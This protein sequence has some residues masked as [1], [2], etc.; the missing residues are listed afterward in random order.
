MTK[1]TYVNINGVWKPLVSVWVNVNGVW[2]KDVMPYVNVND[3]HKECMTYDPSVD[4]VVA[5]SVDHQSFWTGGQNIYRGDEATSHGIYYRKSGVGSWSQKIQS[6]SAG[7]SFSMKI[8]GL[9]H[10][11][12]YEYKAFIIVDAVTYEGSQLSVQTEEG[13]DMETS[14]TNISHDKLTIVGEITQHF[15]TKEEQEEFLEE[16]EEYGVE[17][18]EKGESLWIEEMIGTTL[19]SLIFGKEITGL[20]EETE[21]ECR[22]YIEKDEVRFYGN[23]EE[24]ETLEEP[25]VTTRTAFSIGEDK[26]SSGGSSIDRYDDVEEYGLYWREGTSGSYTKQQTG[27]SLSSSSYTTTITGLDDDT[28]YNFYAYIV[29]DEVEYTGSV[30][31][32]TTDEAED[33]LLAPSITSVNFV[34]FVDRYEVYSTCVD[35]ATYYQLGYYYTDDPDW[36]EPSQT[37]IENNATIVDSGASCSNN[38]VYQINTEYSQDLNGNRDEGWHCHIVRAGNTQGTGP[39]SDAHKE[40]VSGGGG[41]ECYLT[42]ATVTH[43]GKEDDCAELTA[44]RDL[45]TYIIEKGHE[46]LIFDYYKYSKHIV[47]EIKKQKNPEPYYDKIYESVKRVMKYMSN[48]EYDNAFNDYLDMYYELVYEFIEDKK[49]VIDKNKFKSNG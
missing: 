4:T 15:E 3:V 44:M 47:K 24:A 7:T 14:V 12:T 30:K 18:R 43:K 28:T 21:Y 45:R 42:T 48:K 31:S 39:W 22:A 10:S 16:V 38:E 37:G 13:V 25:S 41:G 2:K 20:D 19:N 1:Q 36:A 6:G 23:I 49:E 27:T 9:E 35:D 11:T 17:Y 26:F 40:Y 46:D 34:A 29:V 5:Y 32:V 33:E 8:D